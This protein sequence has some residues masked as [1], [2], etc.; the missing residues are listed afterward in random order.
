[1][2]EPALD[3]EAPQPV[4][5]LVKVRP[6]EVHRPLGRPLGP[7]PPDRRVREQPPVQPVIPEFELLGRQVLRPEDGVRGVV[8]VPVAVEDPPLA[9]HLPEQRRA[10]IRRQDVKRGAVEPV[11]L[12][13]LRHGHERVSPVAVE[14]HDEAA[15]HLDAVLVEDADATAVVLRSR[16]ALPR[17]HQVLVRQR[18]EP[19][20]HPGASGGRHLPDKR[21]VVGEVQRHGRTPH[22]AERAQ[23]PAQEAKVVALPPEVV[24]QED[25]VRLAVGFDLARHVLRVAHAMWHPQGARRQVTEPAPIVAAP[26]GDDARRGQESTARQQVAPRRRVEVVIAIESG[27]VARPK[28][29]SFDVAQDCRPGLHTVADA[30]SVSVRRHL[31]LASVHVHAAKN[32]SRAHRPVPGGEFA[33]ATRERQVHGDADH[34][35]DRP[36]GRRPLQEVLVPVPEPPGRRRGGGDRR[37]REAR[38]QHVLPEAAMRRLRIERIEQQGEALLHRADSRT[39]VERRGDGEGARQVERSPRR[40]E[41]IVGHALEHP[42]EPRNGLAH[43]RRLPR[44]SSHI[45]A[46]TPAITSSG[47]DVPAVRPAARAPVSHSGRTSR[48]S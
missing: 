47:V 36:R 40:V 31:L 42:H 21:D 48:A 28:R 23:R 15:V 10:R 34:L 14:A 4:R 12:D 11:G 6:A 3:Q 19:D 27:Y 32:H 30:H 22:R 39:R 2:H 18:L 8:E 13:P 29:A 35:G 16:R 44:A 25:G 5:T 41:R 46:S 17:V 43:R 33:G 45:R 38:R 37:E 7:A 1:M 20:E 24:V 26:G 9:L